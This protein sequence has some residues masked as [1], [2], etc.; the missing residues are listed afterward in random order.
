MP[1][2]VHVR[3]TP[4]SSFYV[5][6][7]QHLGLWTRTCEA[8]EFSSQAQAHLDLLPLVW[9]LAFF[10]VGRSPLSLAHVSREMHLQ[11]LAC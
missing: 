9:D 8:F 11:G 4:L 6:R 1:V 7:G 10:V 3:P 2:H 5:A